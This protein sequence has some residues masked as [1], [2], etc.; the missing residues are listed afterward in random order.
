M[1]HEVVMEGTSTIRV[2]GLNA[3]EASGVVDGDVTSCAWHGATH[4]CSI[5]TLGV[6]R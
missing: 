4:S 6:T 1:G 3:S 5:V 2:G